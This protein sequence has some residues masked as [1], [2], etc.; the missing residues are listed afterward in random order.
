MLKRNECRQN[1]YRMYN[2]AIHEREHMVVQR[3]YM[4]L[5]GIRN[6]LRKNDGACGIIRTDRKNIF[7]TSEFVNELRAFIP[8][9]VEIACEVQSIYGDKELLLSMLMNLVENGLRASDGDQ[10]VR[11]LK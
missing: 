4:M 7:D 6:A 3:R 10:Q 5:E 9:G 11:V 2:V 8:S 1:V